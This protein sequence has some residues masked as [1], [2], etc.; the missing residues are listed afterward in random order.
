MRRLSAFLA[1]AASLL[2]P[3]LRAQTS[4]PQATAAAAVCPSTATLDDLITAI[5]AAVSGPADKDRT[6]F[7][8]LF[9][10]DARLIP[11]RIAADGRAMPVILD[12][13]GW[14]AAVSKRGSMVL[15]E[16]QIKVRIESWAHIA[17][18]WSTYTTT[19]GADGKVADRGINSIQ[20]VFDGKQWHIIEITWQAEKPDDPVPAKYLP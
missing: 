15:A 4:E 6:C 8:G 12:V 14:I 5:D 11:I 9:L 1:L 17:H 20:A 2:T 19:L 10:P 13:D 7:R 16:H 3:G 18:L